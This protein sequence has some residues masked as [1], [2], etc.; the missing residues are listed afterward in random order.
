MI[1]PPRLARSAAA[2]AALLLLGGCGAEP[3]E[4]AIRAGLELM[5]REWAEQAR[6]ATPAPATAEGTIILPQVNL[7]AEAKRD[8]QITDVRKLV[9]RPAP[10]PKLGYICSAEIKASA[11]GHKMVSRR[12]EGRFISGGTQ[13]VVRDLRPLDVN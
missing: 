1:A 9:C 2:F 12:L 4:A 13:W 3:D 6:G 11:A 10:E 5:H 7:A 8:L